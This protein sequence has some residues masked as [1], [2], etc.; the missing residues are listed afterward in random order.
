MPARS[1]QKPAAGVVR[2]HSI[3]R[4]TVPNIGTMKKTKI[5]CAYTMM[6]EKFIT[7]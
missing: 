1:P 4:I 6:L 3:P 2:F 5:A 7:R